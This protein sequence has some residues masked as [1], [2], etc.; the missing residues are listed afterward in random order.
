MCVSLIRIKLLIMNSN[1]LLS[2]YM[3]ILWVTFEKRG[4]SVVEYLTHDQEVAGSS[5]TGGT[6]LCP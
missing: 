2:N 6:L 5:L 3:V 1:I 4:G